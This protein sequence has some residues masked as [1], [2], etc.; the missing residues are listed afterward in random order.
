MRGSAP[1]DGRSIASVRDPGRPGGVM[2][3]NESGTDQSDLET[4]KGS[5]LPVVDDAEQ[6]PSDDRR[7]QDGI[8][9]CLSGGGY[10]AMLFHV[11]CVIR[12]NE[13]GQLRHLA[14]VSSVSGGS[15]TAGA[16]AVAWPKLTWDDRD[17]ATNLDAEFV[18]PI[19]KF[20]GK[21]VDVPS[22]LRGFV[23]PFSK[24][25][26]Q[27][28]KA[29]SKH[30][31]GDRTLQDL[32][33]AGEGPRF[34]INATNVQ[35]GKL[36]RFSQPYAGDWTVGLWRKP[37][38]KLA[39]AVAASSAFPP[40]LSPHTIDVSGTFDES[41]KGP[42]ATPE[43]TEQVWLSD[44]GVYDNLGLETAL[45]QY[46]TILVSD[47]GGVKKT[48]PTPKRAWPTHMIR[49]LNIIDGQVR[50]LRKRQIIALYER[51]D[52]DGAYWGIQSD[53]DDFGLA[54]PVAITDAER[55]AARKVATRL[56]KLDEPTRHALVNWGYAIAD[57]GLRKHVF[58]T[59]D[60][61]AGL[62]FR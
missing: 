59:A 3:N 37:T 19:L 32:P 61:P 5:L 47:G 41:T 4:G 46:R 2:S 7:L 62:P 12:L 29:Y 48:D 38:N 22:I 42:N 39:D 31:F 18:R 51:G 52:R 36:F 55:D 60:P 11:G 43:F 57:T 27:V 34:V 49:I 24:V 1:E 58:T 9:L 53:I 23:S 56:A 50:S 6:Q 33:A 14:R 15:I 21:T 45:K 28:T 54:D 40:V 16:L 20:A 30:L 25:S 13:L 44:G 10:R 8:A 17:V 35:T 26:D